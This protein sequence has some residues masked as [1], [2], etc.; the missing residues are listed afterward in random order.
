MLPE[1]NRYRGLLVVWVMADLDAGFWIF[2]AVCAIVAG[3]ADVIDQRRRRRKEG[4]E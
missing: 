1:S 3:L 4:D 2:M